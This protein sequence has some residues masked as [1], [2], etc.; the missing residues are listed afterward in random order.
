MASYLSKKPKLSFVDDPGKLYRQRRRAT[1]AKGLARLFISEE[2]LFP[3][4]GFGKMKGLEQLT[5]FCIHRQPLSFL[6]EL[7][8]LTNLMTLDAFCDDDVSY[9][10]SEWE[11]FTSSL[12]VLC[13]RKLVNVGIY[14]TGSTPIHMDTSL[15]TLQSLGTFT[16][17]CIS[18]L[19]IWMGLLVSL[20]LL[21]LKT[22]QFTPE[23]LR[24]LGGLP[25]LE[26]LI[27]EFT[28]SHAA[29]PFTVGGRE[30]FQHLKSFR[31]GILYQLTFMPGSMP[32]LK[33]LD[34][35]LAFSS[36]NCFSDLGIQHREV[37][38]N[39]LRSLA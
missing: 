25:A 35:R 24:V 2:V 14:R 4:E 31:V 29:G 34:V 13:S 19:P 32:T 36:T 11:I 26:N 33:H 22:E 20:E 9:E 1:Q 16:I 6:N 17:S 38:G 37:T 27:L 21:H 7:G 23:D 28:D 12:H 30:L 5:C 3:V 39:T 10:G 8:Q 15:P 18:S